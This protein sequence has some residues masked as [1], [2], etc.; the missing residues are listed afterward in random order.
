M[1]EG[2]RKGQAFLITEA[3]ATIF[4]PPHVIILL[5]GIYYQGH[6]GHLRA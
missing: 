4:P 1:G 6:S 2:N 5:F 3:A